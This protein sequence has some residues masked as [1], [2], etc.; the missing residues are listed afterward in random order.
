MDNYER[1]MRENAEYEKR[2]R[3]LGALTGHSLFQLIYYNHFMTLELEIEA[4][5]RERQR[6]VRER[7]KALQRTADAQLYA[8][9]K[10][11]EGKGQLM[12]DVIMQFDLDVNAPEREKIVKGKGKKPGD[13]ESENT[14][15]ETM[16]HVA[17]GY[18]DVPTIEFLLDRGEFF[19]F[20]TQF[21]T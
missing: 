21:W 1:Q 6:A 17:S 18:C 12:Q 19:V 7:K 11:K 9:A 10:G 8:F 2:K 16:L 20:S 13:A 15:F 5:E 4:E 14:R 3:E